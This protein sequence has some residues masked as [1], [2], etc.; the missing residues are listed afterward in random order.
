MPRFRQTFTC[1]ACGHSASRVVE[2]EPFDPQPD[3]ERLKRKPC[4]KC[5]ARDCSVIQQ[6]LGPQ[7]ADAFNG[8]MKLGRN[9]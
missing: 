8:G 5:G 3:P 7:W 4:S 9:Q 1:N 2:F 6:E